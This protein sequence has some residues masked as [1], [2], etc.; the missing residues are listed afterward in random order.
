M[1]ILISSN[2]ERLLFLASDYDDMKVRTWMQDLQTEGSYTIDDD[3]L[4]T[5]QSDFAG[6]WTDE[7]TCSSTIHDLYEKE[8]VLIDPLPLPFPVCASTVK[9]PATLLRRQS[10]PLLLPIS[11]AVP[12]TEA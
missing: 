2:L 8:K 1:D 9:K 5:I 4:H 7:D 3:L 11:S 10:Y 12:S 6:V